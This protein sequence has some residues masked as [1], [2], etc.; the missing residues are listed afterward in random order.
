MLKNRAEL[1]EIDILPYCEKKIGKDD[2][3]RRVEIPY[4]NWAK[5]MDLLYEFGAE[6]VEYRPLMGPNGSYLFCSREVQNKDGRK[7]GCYF[8]SVEIQIDDKVFQASTP[9]LNGNLVVYDDTL[10]QLRISNAHARAFVKGVA[11]HTGLGF[12]LWV[13]GGEE[14][15][16]TDD[17]SEH[18][19]R[20]CVTRVKRKYADAVAACGGEAELLGL[21]GTRSKLIESTF[22]GA[23]NLAVLEKKLDGLSYDS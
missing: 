20:A 1:R 8:V 19:I 13:K 11:I 9:L 4:L 18:S 6:H 17:L 5:C 23:E 22:T 2:Q 12:D 14:P 21:L 7:C 10:N 3:G 16:A 15:E